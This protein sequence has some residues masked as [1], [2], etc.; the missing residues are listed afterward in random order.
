MVKPLFILKKFYDIFINWC[1][2]KE[3]NVFIIPELSKK[4][5]YITIGINVSTYVRKF[6][7]TFEY[8][9]FVLGLHTS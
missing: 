6:A 9:G 2:I 8:Y 1:Q 3:K 7:P 5:G 4:G